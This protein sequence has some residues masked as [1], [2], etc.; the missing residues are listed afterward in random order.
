[1]TTEIG[2][3]VQLYPELDPEVEAPPVDDD[4]PVSTEAADWTVS[5][6]HDKYKRGRI[7]LQPKYQ[8]QYVWGLRPELPSR[9]IESLLLDIPIVGLPHRLHTS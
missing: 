4:N 7:G 9:L 8:G 3:H 6:L 2:T 5:S 1:M